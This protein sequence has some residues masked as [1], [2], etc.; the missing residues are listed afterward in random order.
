MNL[1]RPA[2]RAARPSVWTPTPAIEWVILEAWRIE[3][4]PDLLR[5]LS[6]RLVAEGVPLWRLYCVVPTLH[7]LYLGSAH[8]WTRGEAEM[9][10]S[11]GDRGLRERPA[12][13][14]NPLR[15]VMDEGY[16]AVRRRLARGE[17]RGEFP[18]LDELAEAGAT[19]Y[20]CIPIEFSNGSRTGVSFTSDGPDGFSAANLKELYDLVPVLARLIE[21]ETLRSTAENVLDTYVGHE[22]GRRILNGQITRGSGETLFAAI[23]YADLRNFTALSEA[24]PRDTMIAL[25]NEYFD[26]MATPVHE[27]GGQVLKFMGDAMLAVFPVDRRCAPAR[28]DCPRQDACDRALDA[29]LEADRRMAGVNRAREA[30]GAAA[31]N[32]GIALHLGEVMYGN[33]GAANRLDFTVIGPAVNLAQRLE[34][35]CKTLARRPLLSRPFAEACLH[36]SESLGR[37]DLRGVSG[38]HEVFAPRA[39]DSAAQ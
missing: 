33:V 30:G 14:N 23:W 32:Y 25:L 28:S 24:L 12:Y 10:R 17:G 11:L 29:A 31:L 38:P 19:D 3:S 2:D 15:L 13:T 21:R 7:P 4:V 9:F 6:E 34:A 16:G 35:L 36:P 20:V 18:L 37:F 39:P 27:H 22:A 5:A 26:A 1:V 8:R